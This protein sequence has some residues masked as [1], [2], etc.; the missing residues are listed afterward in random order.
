MLRIV[1]KLWSVWF[2]LLSVVPLVAQNERGSILGHVEDSSGAVVVGARVT[3]RNVN[4]DVK[5]TFTTTSSGDYVFLHLI[6]G[7]YEVTVENQGFQSAVA[8]GL[9]LQ[10]DQ[11]LRQDF[12]LQVGAVQQQVTVAADAQMLQSDN[13]TIGQV[14]TM[15]QI[16]ALPISGRDFTNLLQT[17]AGVTQA[18][19][20]IQASIFDPHGL[21]AQFTMV[22][23]DGSRPSSISYIIDGITDTDLFFSRPINVPPAD[24]IQEFKLQNGLYSSQYGFGSAQVNVAITSGTNRLH[25]GAY[26]FLENSAFQPKNPVNT[27]LKQNVAGFTGFAKPPMRQNQFGFQL[28]GPLWIPKIYN[29]KNRSFWFVGYEGGRLRQT[30]AAQQFQV[31]TVQERSGNFSDWPYPIYNPASTGTVPSTAS[32]P[33]GRVPF[34]GNVIPPSQISQQ[35]V[36]FLNLIYP[37]PNISCTL[38]CLNYAGSSNSPVDTNVVTARVDQHITDRDQLSFTLN[39]GDLTQSTVSPLPLLSTSAVVHSYLYGLQYQRNFSNSL[40]GQFNAGFTRQ[41]YNNGSPSTYDSTIRSKLGLQNEPNP[42]DFF[43][44]PIMTITSSYSGPVQGNNANREINN[45]Y[46]TSG[47]LSWIHGPHTLNFGADIRRIQLQN[48]S[49]FGTFGSLTFNGSYTA[50]NPTTAGGAPSAVNGNAAADL[51]LGFP[52]SVTAPSAYV[53][54]INLRGTRW[55]FSSRTI[56]A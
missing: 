13:A 6:P 26:D 4:T 8:Q 28:G 46:Q 35:G 45:I 49:G 20:G 19:G 54:P 29:G 7:T 56:G 12:S 2:L 15:R 11:T 50:A 41:N 47:T 31:P 27:F 30:T 40:V 37:T 44:V 16:Q 36:A 17:N 34:A 3:V 25:G 14:V 39:N 10:V 1:Q 33:T 5:S 51:V 32:N 18:S 24:A 23:V 52:R 43:G 42:A 48:F 9:I 38:P 53:A 22:S 55:D 21:N